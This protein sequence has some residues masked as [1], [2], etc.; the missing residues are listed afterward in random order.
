MVSAFDEMRWDCT[1]LTQHV[2]Q[3]AFIP[4]AFLSSFPSM[5]SAIYPFHPFSSPPHHSPQTNLYAYLFITT[6]P[7]RD[8]PCKVQQEWNIAKYPNISRLHLHKARNNLWC[9]HM[10]DWWHLTQFGKW[11]SFH[12]GLQRLSQETVHVLPFKKIQSRWLYFGSAV[13]RGISLFNI[14]HVSE[15]VWTQLHISYIMWWTSIWN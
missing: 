14:Q 8:L 9:Q 12:V 5:L 6:L 15:P 4:F 13:W 11:H 2:K 7:I 1:G 3:P 10:P